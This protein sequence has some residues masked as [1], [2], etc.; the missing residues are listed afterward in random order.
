MSHSRLENQSIFLQSKDSRRHQSEYAK[1]LAESEQQSRDSRDPTSASK[2]L[3]NL[4]MSKMDVAHMGQENLHTR[5]AQRCVIIHPRQGRRTK[6]TRNGRKRRKPAPAT[7]KAA[8]GHG[9]LLVVLQH[10]VEALEVHGV[11]A[12]EHRRLPQRIKQVLPC[13]KSKVKVSK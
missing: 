5:T 7:A 11:A 6:A 9:R 2:A 4:S 10:L 1:N 3:K 13:N 12:P 8:I